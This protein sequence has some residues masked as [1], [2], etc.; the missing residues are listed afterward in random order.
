MCEKG[1]MRVVSVGRE[2]KGE[3]KMRSD[4][5]EFQV[6]ITGLAFRSDAVGKVQETRLS[7]IFSGAIRLGACNYFNLRMRLI[8]TF[9]YSGLLGHFLLLLLTDTRMNM[10]WMT[11]SRRP[12]NRMTHTVPELWPCLNVWAFRG[13]CALWTTSSSSKKALSSLA[14]RLLL[15]IKAI[16]VDG[17]IIEAGNRIW[18]FGG[19]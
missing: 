12:N 13:V 3:D 15:L 14:S 2:K 17:T 6:I 7:S 5:R 8:F 1:I 4:C 19:I 9:C 11:T 16:V 18:A 10:G